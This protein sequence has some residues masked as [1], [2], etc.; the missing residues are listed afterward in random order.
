MCLIRYYDKFFSPYIE[1][2]VVEQGSHPTVNRSTLPVNCKY[3]FSRD[4]GPFDRERCFMTGIS[5]SDP[6]RKFLILS[7]NDIYLETLD[8]RANLR[9]CERYDYVTGFTR[10]FDLTNEDSQRLRATRST[11]GI[12]ITKNHSPGNERHS[13]CRFLNREAIQV[14]PFLSLQGREQVRIFQSPNH[15]LR[16]QPD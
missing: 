4:D 5:H 7:D 14:G 15:A 1:M 13:Y 11:R 16:L 6:A 10:I 9:M 12:D 3:I 8:I 2:V